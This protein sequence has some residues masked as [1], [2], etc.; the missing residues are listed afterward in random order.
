MC[1][2]NQCCMDFKIPIPK[3]DI[4]CFKVLTKRWKLSVGIVWQ[5]FLVQNHISS[6]ASSPRN[7][8]LETA[9]LHP[10]A[11]GCQLQPHNHDPARQIG[12]WTR[13]EG[14]YNKWLANPLQSY[15]N[16]M[17]NTLKPRPHVAPKVWS[18]A[19]ACN[20]FSSKLKALFF[21]YMLKSLS[22]KNGP[23]NVMV[24][25]N[26][27]LPRTRKRL[28]PLLGLPMHRSVGSAPRLCFHRRCGSSSSEL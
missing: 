6:A 24:F 22:T 3:A 14:L 2:G 28:L 15:Y 23:N 16:T 7:H 4:T 9:P 5:I 10:S 11:P 27:G 8:I 17:H 19:S 25:R 12:S 18:H 1:I 20:Q 13:Y 26:K 21:Y